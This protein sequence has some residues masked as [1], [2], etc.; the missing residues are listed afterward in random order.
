MMNLKPVL[1]ECPYDTWANPKVRE[2]F[3]SA[4]GLKLSGYLRE[5]AYGVLP[6]DT[7]DFVATHHLICRDTDAGLEPLICAKILTLKRC[8]THSLAFPPLAALRTI[9][10]ASVRHLAV[11]EKI[12]ARFE[13]NP[14]ALTYVGGITILPEARRDRAL[15]ARLWDGLKAAWLSF[16]LE[17]G[18]QESILFSAVRFKMNRIFGS[19]GYNEL[20]V[21]GQV[22]AP[23]SMPTLMNG[24]EA[25]LEHRQEISKEALALVKRHELWNRTRVELRVPTRFAA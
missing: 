7:S 13:N 21:D 4:I 22:L 19:I 15:V 3:S 10:R 5:Y 8:Q 2:Y 16:D 11:V 17:N 24:H 18:V 12:V 25:W 20:E 6:F 23:V 1:I 14:Q 9:P